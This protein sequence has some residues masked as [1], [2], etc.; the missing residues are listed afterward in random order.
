M[1]SDRPAARGRSCAI[2]AGRGRMRASSTDRHGAKQSRMARPPQPKLDQGS[3]LCMPKKLACLPC[4]LPLRLARH[5][6]QQHRSE[7]RACAVSRG[8]RHSLLLLFIASTPPYTSSPPS[9]H[10][11][12][13]AS[14]IAKQLT[15]SS[16]I[17]QLP[18]V[19]YYEVYD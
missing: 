13:S 12:S 8:H 14:S 2:P 18:T 19:P 4:P 16:L 6:R 9:A 11:P 10:S 17:L 3:S 15:H 7:R 5:Q 1:W